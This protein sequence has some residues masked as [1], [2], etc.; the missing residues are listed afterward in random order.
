MEEDGVPDYVS[1]PV[2]DGDHHDLLTG[3][4]HPGMVEVK[5]DGP[6]VEGASVYPD[7]H[8]DAIHAPGHRPRHLEVEA[9]LTQGAVSDPHL[10]DQCKVY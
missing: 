10:G 2:L 1:P 5:A 9:V 3:G 8:R 4:Q 6:R 7:H